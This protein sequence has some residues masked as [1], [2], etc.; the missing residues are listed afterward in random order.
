MALQNCEECGGTVSEKAAVCPHCGAPGPSYGQSQSEPAAH[1]PAPKKSKKSLVVFSVIAGLILI[2]AFGS[3]DDETE[4]PALQP[5][6]EVPALLPEDEVAATSNE[7]NEER[8]KG[9]H[10]LSVWNGANRDFARKI[11]N[12]MR[13]PDS[14]EHIETKITPVDVNGLH[15]VQM[16]F[17]ARNGYGGMTNGVAVAYI[18]Q[19]DCKV[20]EVL[21]VENF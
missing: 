12:Q 2:A 20:S 18:N 6:D 10:C 8:R 21:S 14:F 7:A 13:D 5:E 17:R 4:K 1:I 11:E 19:D 15:R 9:L 3:P 16:T